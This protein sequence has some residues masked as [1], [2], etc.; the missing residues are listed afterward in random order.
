MVLDELAVNKHIGTEVIIIHLSKRH[1][2]HDL[3]RALGLNQMRSLQ[4]IKDT[5]KI[6]K[7]GC[8]RLLHLS[9]LLHNKKRRT[10]ELYAEKR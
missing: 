6:H 7:E 4:I 3:I 9:V 1:S 8:T 5:R 10:A 2:C